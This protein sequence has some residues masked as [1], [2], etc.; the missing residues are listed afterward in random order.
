M[1]VQ[2]AKAIMQY[3]STNEDGVTAV[4]YS[5][6][7]AFIAAVIIAAVIVLGGTVDGIFTGFNTDFTSAVGH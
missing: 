6:L 3:L 7:V 2:L 1:S 4:E 5:L